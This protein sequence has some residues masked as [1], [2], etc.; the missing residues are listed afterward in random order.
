M[1][2]GKIAMKLWTTQISNWRRA[3]GEFLDITVKT[4]R[5]EFAPDWALLRDYKTGTIGMAEYKTRY[6]A[7]MR[8]SWHTC[9]DVW[10]ELLE[11]DEVTI[12]CYCKSGDFC[13]RLLLRDLLEKVCES[14]NIEFE[15]CGEIV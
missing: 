13:H 8:G 6:T 14:Q 11:K 12:G 3:K 1:L 10:R 2:M 4:G 9:N 15:Y 5:Q 7:K